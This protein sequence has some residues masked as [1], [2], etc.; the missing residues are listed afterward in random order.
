M[1]LHENSR[2]ST[3]KRNHGPILHPISAASAIGFSA[4]WASFSGIHRHTRRPAG[5]TLHYCE[6]AFV[7]GRPFER[8]ARHT[9][10]NFTRE[11][12][13]HAGTIFDG[14]LATHGR[15]GRL[16]GGTDASRSRIY[17]THRPTV[18]RASERNRFARF[19]NARRL[20]GQ[21]RRGNALQTALGAGRVPPAEVSEAVTLCVTF[22]SNTWIPNFGAKRFEVGSDAQG[23]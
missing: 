20:R 3:A 16:A 22:T 8:K 19:Q 21:G 18:R 23:L 13:V 11:G 2:I 14:P 1:R 7:I 15:D 4:R 12:K 5:A 6:Y 17:Q 10:L 9:S